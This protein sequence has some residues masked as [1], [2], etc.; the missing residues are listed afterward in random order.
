MLWRNRHP[1]LDWI[2]N[3]KVLLAHQL[4][5]RRLEEAA[6]YLLEERPTLM[7]AL[8][9][10]AARLARYV[11]ANYPDAPQPLVPFVKVGGEQLY[12][13]ERE[14]IVKYLGGRVV[15]FY[16]CTEVGPISAECP[17]G[18]RHVLVENVH[19]TLDRWTK[20]PGAQWDNRPTTAMAAIEPHNTPAI[21]VR[22]ADNVSFKACSVAWGK[23]IPDTFTH[24]LQ[25]ENVTG[26]DHTGLKGEAA[27]PRRDRAISVG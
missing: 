23:N 2:K 5:Q 21:H 10:A 14:E 7:V 25:A 20:Y 27:H 22:H 11:G 26:L 17:E 12:P 1:I 24:A 13:F 15:E 19:L 16:G 3:T 6:R 4:T 9:S 8:P 18:S